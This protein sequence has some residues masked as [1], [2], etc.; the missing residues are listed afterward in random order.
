MTEKEVRM[1]GWNALWRKIPLLVLAAGVT[2]SCAT[3]KVMEKEEGMKPFEPLPAHSGVQPVVSALPKIVIYKT[4]GN[5]NRNV[6]VVMDESRTKIVAYPAPSD[7]YRNGRLA[8][9][10]ELDGGYLLDNRGINANTVFLDYTYE[11]YAAME[12]AP[13]LQDLLEHVKERYPF[14]EMYYTERD[15]SGD[16]EYY[17]RVIASGFKDCRKVALQKRPVPSP[18]AR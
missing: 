6:P 2:V 1:C 8:T 17:N 15:T 18:P 5:F 7:L 10:T 16:V 13:S 4:T 11:E 9:P 3:E 12:T 14:V